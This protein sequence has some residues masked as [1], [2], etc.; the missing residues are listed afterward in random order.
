MISG[1]SLQ[2]VS[3]GEPPVGLPNVCELTKNPLAIVTPALTKV[4]V[5]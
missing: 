5:H 1:N 3:L 4:I 2:V